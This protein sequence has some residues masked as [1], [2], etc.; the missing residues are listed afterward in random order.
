[1]F[2]N[3]N[4]LYINGEWCSGKGS[5]IN[6]NNPFSGETILKLNSATEEDID[7]AYH[8][9]AKAQKKW[10]KV[11]FNKKRDIFDAAV[12][13]MK[14][15]KDEIVDLLIRESGSTRTKA[16]LEYELAFEALR[17]SAIYPARVH[18]EIVP[19]TTP[20]KESRLYR[21]PLGVVGVISPWNFP[22]H[23]TVRS[24][25]P[26]IALGN[27]L[28]LKAATQTP[29]TGGLLVAKIF[30]KAGLPPGV[31]NVIVAHGKDMGDLFL[32]HPIPKLISFTGS[33]EVGKKI[34]KICGEKLKKVT[35]EL[36]GNGPFIVLDDVNLDRTI[37]AALYGKFL[38]SGQICIAVNR[39][40]VQESVYDKFCERF[41]KRVSELKVGDPSKKDTLVGPLINKNQVK[42]IREWVKSSV[43]AGAKVLYEGKT[44]DEKESLLAP[45]VLAN[46]TNDMD[47][48]RNEI[49]GP[50][51]AIISVKDDK[52]IAHIANDTQYGLAA[53]IHSA[54]LERA[55]LLSKKLKVGMVHIN[56]ESVYDEPTAAFGGEK[57]SG[58]G[59]FGSDF[60]MEEFTTVQWQTVQFKSKKYP[61]IGQKFSPI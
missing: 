16:V 58:I 47:I 50:V 9:A 56:G 44:E 39:F 26:A 1:M 18:S 2:E 48:A 23:L 4:K 59:R 22:L 6:V 53:S 55:L 5:E 36:G 33:T 61:A 13:I 57:N 34:G 37:D 35:L 38:H 60:C 32:T 30:E 49:F 27:A 31:L 11:L 17:Y 19:S 21:I 20:N 25:A 42:K 14:D 41:V 45:I 46:V 40:L 24:V 15:Q 8:S 52:E 7:R 3:L 54:D 29:R 28:V 43:K 51:A 12:C 10:A